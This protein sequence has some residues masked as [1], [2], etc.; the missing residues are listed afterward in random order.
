MFSGR[1]KHYMSSVSP[2]PQLPLFN[3][4][5]SPQ[6]GLLWEKASEPP[7]LWNLTKG[8]VEEMGMNI[9]DLS[10]DS[11]GEKAQ[12]INKVLISVVNQR[13]EVGKEKK[14]G[15]GGRVNEKNMLHLISYEVSS[16]V[17]CSEGPQN[18]KSPLQAA[19]SK[20]KKNL[21]DQHIAHRL[22]DCVITALPFL[23]MLW[24]TIQ[25]KHYLFYC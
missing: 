17:I 18:T 25:T 5:K 2:P 19:L 13:E 8:S 20:K 3:I 12:G 10:F 16:T 15:G 1:K 6:L 22:C 4:N 11:G 21:F 14:G 23:C 9:A 7:S 24:L